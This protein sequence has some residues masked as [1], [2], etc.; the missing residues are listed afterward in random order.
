MK[1][2][3][4]AAV[5]LL[6]LMAW[7]P[8]MAEVQYYTVEPINIMPADGQSIEVGTNVTVQ[9][10]D[11]MAWASTY[12]YYEI[13]IE[14]VGGMHR[15]WYPVSNSSYLDW[16]VLTIPFNMEGNEDSGNYRVI[17]PQ[18][19]VVYAEATSFGNPE[20]QINYT[21]GS[22]SSSGITIQTINTDPGTV[23][24]LVNPICI[25]LSVD[26]ATYNE[27]HAISF[28]CN[29]TNMELTVNLNEMFVDMGYFNW[30]DINITDA[31]GDITDPGTYFLIIP[32]GA[33]E[34]DGA[35]NEFIMYSW[36]IEQQ[37]Q[38]G[39]IEDL[40]IVT[41]DPSL[42]NPWY[43]FNEDETFT[44]VFNKPETIATLDCRIDDLTADEWFYTFYNSGW[45]K[46]EDNSFTY[47]NNAS[48]FIFY[49]NH[50]YQF[51]FT[52]YDSTNYTDRQ[53]IG[54][55]IGYAMGGTPEASSYSDITVSV[56]N[57]TP[58][59][60]IS[61]ANPNVTFVFS[62]P[63][64]FVSGYATEGGQGAATGAITLVESNEDNTEIT[65]AADPEYLANQFGEVNYLVWFQDALG[66]T[67]RTESETSDF[68][69]YYNADNG[70]EYGYIG[71]RYLILD[72]GK[73]V[74]VTPAAGTVSAL[75]EFKFEYSIGI[76]WGAD[77]Y[78]S[79]KVFDADGA[80]VAYVA[81]IQTQLEIEGDGGN[82]DAINTYIMAYLNTTINEPG[83]YTLVIPWTALTLGT[84]FNADGYKGQEVAYTIVTTGVEDIEIAGS[85][86]FD[87][88]NLQG[89]K[90]LSGA[91]REALNNLP[92]GLYIV[93]GEKVYVK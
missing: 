80:E 68:Y 3:T 41:T 22:S 2:F 60:I 32:E 55:V 43:S 66:R 59:S 8:A 83:D 46:N 74:T 72:A 12:S 35:V 44:V 47:T 14:E 7:T 93:N 61:A 78:S 10:D 20:I 36:T 11:Q 21:V 49:E 48:D 57:P 40:E 92:R 30:W 38:G 19:T 37:N 29:G 5:A 33:F 9:F 13:Y 39:Q 25:S 24:S 58:G 15:T 51:T 82:A 17:I 90:V 77:P 79:V 42:E 67:I 64:F 81:S 85:A 62:G 45:V 27:D 23:T 53:V 31:G 89:I 76:G 4:K 84:Q 91:S 86:A 28:T 34:L 1:L 6:G 70:E 88:Y 52:C 26:N 87:V 18:G 16:D 65:V 73:T 63:A 54:T 50:E 75:S 71:V 69:Y 56:G